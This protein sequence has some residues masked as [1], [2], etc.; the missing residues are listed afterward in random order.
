MHRW[1]VSST[2][3]GATSMSQL[4]ENIAAYDV[5]LSDEVL[6]E[7]EQIHLTMMNPAP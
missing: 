6:S 3:I 7:I 2:I 4:Q 5:K 1:C